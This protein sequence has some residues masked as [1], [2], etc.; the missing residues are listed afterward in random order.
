[1]WSTI[2]AVHLLFTL[3]RNAP[4]VS[5]AHKLQVKIGGYQKILVAEVATRQL[6]NIYIR[7]NHETLMKLGGLVIVTTSLVL[8]TSL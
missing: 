5:P 3:L 4:P 2:K 1:M 6:E 8:N 7:T